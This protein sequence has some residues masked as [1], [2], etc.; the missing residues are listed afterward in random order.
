[1]HVLFVHQN[2]PAQFKYLAPALA[3]RGWKCSFVTGRAEGSLPGVEKIPYRTTTGASPGSHPC[4]RPFENNVGHALG[5]YEALKGRPDV[6]PDLVVA[7]SGFGS[8]LFLPYLTDAPIINFFEW[9]YRPTGQDLGYRPEVGLPEV[10][11]LRC[12]TRNAMTLLDLDNCDRGW[13]PNEY[14]R[15][16]FPA[17]F[18][19][20]IEVIPE[21]VD[22]AIYSP[23]RQPANVRRVR[24]AWQVPDEA[25]VVTYVSRGLEMMR[26]FDVFMRAAKLISERDRNVV[27]MVVGTD[28]AYYGP[29]E[30]L[31]GARTFREHVLASGDYDL[32]RF[33]FTGQVPEPALADILS[34]SDLHIYL[35]APFV[36][37]W[38]FLDAMACGCT[39][40]ASDQ[41]GVREYVDGGRTGLLCEFF[42]HESLA[43]MACDVLARPEAF[44]C[45]GDAAA[46][47][48]RDGYALDVTLPR[49]V[50]FFERVA[51]VRRTP[52]LAADLIRPGTLRQDEC[53]TTPGESDDRRLPDAQPPRFE[54]ASAAGDLCPRA[55]SV[56]P[57]G[58]DASPFW[59]GGV[60]PA[61]SF[62]RSK[63][64]E[65]LCRRAL[66]LSARGEFNDAANH[67]RDYL[68][69]NDADHFMWYLAACVALAVGDTGA[70][71]KYCVEMLARFG[72]A[73]EPVVCERVSKI[74]ALVPGAVPDIRP[75]LELADRCQRE[76][77]PESQSPWCSLAKGIAAYRAGEPARALES[78]AASL[79]PEPGGLRRLTARCFMAM[80]ERELNAGEP[81]RRGDD[82]SRLIEMKVL[83]RP[84]R[85]ESWNDLIICREARGQVERSIGNGW[86]G[87]V[88]QMPVEGARTWSGGA[89]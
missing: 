20:K 8:S 4:V 76:G 29:D 19:E 13:C 52:T 86:S 34:A 77:P 78:L 39:V 59:D 35:T 26:G 88:D 79:A 83:P 58:H 17:E 61:R 1:M 5:V 63:S 10:Q 66:A 89:N 55:G 44:R 82:V 24:D 30:S 84:V 38:S 50:S 23:K 45:F 67:F 74:C 75:V 49:I 21:G 3:E 15:R 22:T 6:R 72:D 12:R 9:F 60:A 73:R 25:R 47:F 31:T 48:I 85:G 40:L 46:R 27:F 7:H 62:K 36:P 2:F 80:A 87:A 53:P 70:Y 11:L 65:A 32:S 18:R 43:S 42:D 37:S 68:D 51:S 69:R 71:R 16:Q 14:Q 41:P 28:K 81:T 54:T 56:V 33:R 64:V 57:W